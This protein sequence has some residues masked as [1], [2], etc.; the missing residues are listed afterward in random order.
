M[1]IGTLTRGD[2]F[3]QDLEIPCTYI[4]N[5]EY[6]SQKKKKK[7]KKKKERKK[8]KIIPIVISTISHFW[9]PGLTTSW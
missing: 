6:K 7:K 5:N 9:S 8:E 4:K 2:F 3:R 1:G